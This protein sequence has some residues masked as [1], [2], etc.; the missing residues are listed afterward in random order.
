MHLL[1]LMSIFPRGDQLGHLD[2]M[3]QADNDN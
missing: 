1:D 3:K 2:A